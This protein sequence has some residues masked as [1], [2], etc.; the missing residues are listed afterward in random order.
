[1]EFLVFANP[2]NPT[3]T[4]LSADEIEKILNETDAKILVDETYIEFTDMSTYS[5][6][7][8]IDSY[9]NLAVV[10]G[11]SKFF[12]LPGIRLGYGLSSDENFLN[13]FK[14]KEIL[15]QINSVAEI[16]GKVMF[17][18]KEYI[19]KIFN[20]IDIHLTFYISLLNTFHKT[21][22]VI[23]LSIDCPLNFILHLN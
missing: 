19:D 10:R 22:L 16:C 21:D 15:W 12:A 3:G 17:S 8:L 14:N 2:N 5:S 11:T 18:D 13:Y 7:K 20:F 9:K 23:L 6:T 4:I 1:M